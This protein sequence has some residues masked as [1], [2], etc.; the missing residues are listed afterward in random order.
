MF[1]KAA[2]LHHKAHCCVGGINDQTGNGAVHGIGCFIHPSYVLT[3][4]HVLR[5]VGD[6]Y[7]WALVTT[8]AGGFKCEIRK[9]WPA[10]DIAVLKVVAP[11]GDNSVPTEEQPTSAPLSKADVYIGSAVGVFSRIRLYD[12]FGVKAHFS[13]G[14]ISM[15]MFPEDSSST[16]NLALSN[17]VIQVGFS[18]S[19]VFLPDGSV[20]GVIVRMLSFPVD[21]GDPSEGRYHLP[22]MAPLSKIRAEI[23]DVLN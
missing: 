1:E 23:E 21:F 13:S 12:E 18:G 2:A 6:R 19:A 8:A 14:Y 3:A 5:P 17:I 11:I 15:L 7:S 10:W 9:T 16:Y 20:V 22:I 4:A